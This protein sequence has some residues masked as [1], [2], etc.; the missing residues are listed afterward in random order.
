MAESSSVSDKNETKQQERY[1]CDPF[2]RHSIKISK[3]LRVL[4][5]DM[6]Q[7]VGEISGKVI[8][9]GS[10]LCPSCRKSSHYEHEQSEDEAE[11]SDDEPNLG[12][13]NQ[14]MRN[15]NCSPI[16]L[17]ALHS[18]DRPSYA[19]RKINEATGAIHKKISK[20]INVDPEQVQLSE[21]EECTGC[22]DLNRLMSELKVK[23]E[24]ATRIE[25]IKLLTLVPDSW[26]QEKVC[27]EFDVSNYLVK[28]ARKLKCERGILADTGMKHGKTLSQDV[29]DSVKNFFEDDEFSRLCLGK[30]DFVS[31]KVD[32]K[33]VHK[34]KR[35]LLRNLKELHLEFNKST[36]LHIGLS[37]FCSLRPSWCV[38]AVADPGGR[39]RGRPPPL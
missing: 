22:S 35:L 5:V 4:S 18:R 1:C 8:K 12:E 31:V 13:L 16:K 10:K 25:K 34:Q 17:H 32:G 38:T 11:S 15:I 9:P 29:I 14:S 28:K 27:R 3:S 7:I 33:R 39:R 36:V 20:V 24:A 6:A 26:T 30:K 19:K 2:N 37:K 23:C 21:I